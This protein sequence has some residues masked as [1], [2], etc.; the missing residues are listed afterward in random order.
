MHTDQNYGVPFQ[1]ESCKHLLK[2]GR[3]A[4]KLLNY[5]N[6]SEMSKIQRFGKGKIMPISMQDW[7]DFSVVTAFDV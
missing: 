4:Q 5:Q 1:L 6:Y 2:G 3:E 7:R